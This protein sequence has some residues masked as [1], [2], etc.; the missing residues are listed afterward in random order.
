MAQQ[1]QTIRFCSSGAADRARGRSKACPQPLQVAE[2]QVKMESRGGPRR[3][4][5][6]GLTLGAILLHCSSARLPCSSGNRGPEMAFG[7][8]EERLSQFGDKWQILN[9]IR[10]H[11][12]MKREADHGSQL[13]W[14]RIFLALGLQSFTPARLCCQAEKM[15]EGLASPALLLSAHLG[16]CTGTCVP[17]ARGPE[18][19]CLGP[20]L[21]CLSLPRAT[22]AC[23][24]CAEVRD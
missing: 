18:L 12:L 20:G 10:E 14:D 13:F 8:T 21:T 11:Y 19:L 23:P 7:N 5:L 24:A 3:E 2:F 17:C 9:A 6:F 22:A 4:P 16:P 15:A 1:Q